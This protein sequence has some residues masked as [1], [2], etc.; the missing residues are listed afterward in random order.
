MR[1]VSLIIQGKTWSVVACSLLGISSL[2]AQTSEPAKPTQEPVFRVARLEN[3]TATPA[4]PETAPATAMPVDAANSTS[5]V[6]VANAST[7]A[8]P[9]GRAPHPLDQAIDIANNRLAWIRTDVV[10]YQ[11]IMVKRERINGTLN[12]PE[13]MKIKIRNRRTLE[14]GQ[15]VPFSVYM[16]FLK[17][18]AI[19]GREVIY[20]EGMNGGKIVAHDTGL[21]GLI[22]VFLDPT[23]FMA[24]KNSRYPIYD[25]GLENL[26]AKLIEKAERD[27]AA[28][29]CQVDYIE[30]AKIND[31]PCMKI[32]VLHEEQRVPFDFHMAEVFI[33][34]ETKLPVRY[35][36][37][38]WPTTAGGEPQLLEEYTYLNLELNKGFSDKDFDHKNPEYEYR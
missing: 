13:Y 32:K 36:A 23:G 27:R 1:R 21:T 26:V 19:R 22:T 12:E 31:R 35:A 9:T 25:A 29:M 28:G 8:A 20:V 4:T 18:K 24:M 14:S 34:N 38:D 5:P 16:R 17:P 2:A 10:D 6:P 11:A 7:S 15:Q 3:A 37:Y 33:D 30:S